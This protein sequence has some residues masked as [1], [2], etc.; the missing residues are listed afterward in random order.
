MTKTIK[1][2]HIEAKEACDKAVKEF[3]EKHG[4]P[5]YCGFSWV[6]IS[7]TRTNSAHSKEFKA[8]GYDNSYKPRTLM[9]WNPS[10][11]VT[12]SMDVKDAGSRAYAEVF[13]KYGH[14]VYARSR[15]D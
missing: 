5:F 1:D 2:I 6:E 4:E 13:R 12:Q 14:P 7:V 10:E 9:L 3:I 11:H 8:I 15:A